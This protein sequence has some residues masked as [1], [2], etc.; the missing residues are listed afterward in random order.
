ML[1]FLSQ[2]YQARLNDAN[3]SKPGINLKMTDKHFAEYSKAACLVINLS[4]CEV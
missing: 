3:G 2:T 1:T 4:V